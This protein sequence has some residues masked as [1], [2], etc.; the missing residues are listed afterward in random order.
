MS[1]EEIIFT[2]I[3]FGI[4]VVTLFVLLFMRDRM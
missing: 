3:F 4:A 1:P 2:R